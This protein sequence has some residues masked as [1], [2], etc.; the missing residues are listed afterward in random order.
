MSV[1]IYFKADVKYIRQLRSELQ[2]E[3]YERKK[4]PKRLKLALS[5]FE[6]HLINVAVDFELS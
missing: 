5:C 1:G 3:L 2:F 6:E 4:V